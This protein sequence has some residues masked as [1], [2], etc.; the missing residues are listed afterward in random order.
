[1]GLGKKT[2]KFMLVVNI[3]RYTLEVAALIV[4]VVTTFFA[5]G[6]ALG[7]FVI[8]AAI[9]ALISHV[10]NVFRVALLDKKKAKAAGKKK[11][12]KSKETA[13]PTAEKNGKTRKEKEASRRGTACKGRSRCGYKGGAH[14]RKYG[15]ALHTYHIP[16]THRRLHSHA[17]Q[18]AESRVFESIPR[19]S[20]RTYF[21]HSRLH[22]RRQKRKV[23]YLHLYLLCENTRPCF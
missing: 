10:I 9:L 5:E 2:N 20:E 3:I 12:K 13:K 18:R 16:R 21:L 11:A 1:M 19:T 14:G 4:I 17:C 6:V 23:L 15:K 22:G 7:N 8:I